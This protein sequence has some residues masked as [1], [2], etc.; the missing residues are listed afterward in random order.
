[1][2]P[3]WDRFSVVISILD[4]SAGMIFVGSG[5]SVLLIFS[6]WCFFRGGPLGLSFPPS[7]LGGVGRGYSCCEMVSVTT[8]GCFPRSRF[9][10]F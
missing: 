3:F 8:F 7:R 5:T 1:M 6:F 9:L 4:I 2:I 10:V